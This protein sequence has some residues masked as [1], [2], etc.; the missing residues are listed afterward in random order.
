MIEL[1]NV[2]KSRFK[3]INFSKIRDI[4]LLLDRTIE[5]IKMN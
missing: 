4:F 2:I 1:K 5:R 3:L